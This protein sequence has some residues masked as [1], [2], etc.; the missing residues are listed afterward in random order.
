M[1]A[2]LIVGIFLAFGLL[3]ALSWWSKTDTKT[4]K[5]ALAGL[6]AL[7]LFASGRGVMALVPVG[8]TVWRFFSGWGGESPLGQN[9]GGAKDSAS[10]DRVG[11]S[12][13]RREALEVLGLSD[14]VTEEDVQGA[15]RRL[16]AKAHPDA[17]GTKWM[18]AQL[19]AARDCL[20]A[21]L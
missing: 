2:Y 9:Q 15:Y 21:S 8:Y 5:V 16:M 19:N 17:G 3:F 12:M 13:S 18:A 10:R 14:P 4:A 6:L 1:I 7:G 20:L 11:G